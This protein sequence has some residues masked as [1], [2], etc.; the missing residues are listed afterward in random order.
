ML[1]SKKFEKVNKMFVRSGKE[2]CIEVHK[3]FVKVSGGS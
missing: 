3:K 1:V 2:I